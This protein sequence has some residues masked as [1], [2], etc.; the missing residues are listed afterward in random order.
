MHLKFV[1]V[2]YLRESCCADVT[3]VRLFTGVYS[4]MTFELKGVWTCVGAVA[5]LIRALSSMA[6]VVVEE[7][8]RK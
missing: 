1:V 8:K 7:D 3:F 4:H 2:P 6:S 5:A